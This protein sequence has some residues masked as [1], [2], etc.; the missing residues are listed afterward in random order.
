MNHTITI[1][2]PVI[3]SYQTVTK[4]KELSKEISKTD[5]D[6]KSRPNTSNFFTWYD[7]DRSKAILESM[8]I[9][10]RI[11]PI[12]DCKPAKERIRL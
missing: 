5:M 3:Y 2:V 4:Q 7:S 10:I 11:K 12:E 1:A 9:S 6:L 8:M